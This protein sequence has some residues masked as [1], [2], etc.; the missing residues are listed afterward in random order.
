MNEDYFQ[1]KINKFVLL[2]GD[3]LLARGQENE[4]MK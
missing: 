4:D 2:T 3:L 1:P